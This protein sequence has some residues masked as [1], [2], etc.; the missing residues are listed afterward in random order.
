MKLSPSTATTGRP[1]ASFTS[2]APDANKANKRTTPTS[3]RT[4]PARPR[5][6][7]EPCAATSGTHG[8]RGDHRSNAAVLPDNKI[9]YVRDVTYSED[10]SQ[11]RTGNAPR[12]MASFRNLAIGALRRAGYTNIAAALRK[13]GRDFTRPLTLLGIRH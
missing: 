7:L 9:H 1:T 3:K 6:L 11:V 4:M 5:R 12:I 8:S 10:A 2:T 13:T